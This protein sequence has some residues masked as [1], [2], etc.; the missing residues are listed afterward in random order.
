MNDC[1][2]ISSSAL[3][4]WSSVVCIAH[5]LA[6]LSPGPCAVPPPSWHPD[7]S[8]PLTTPA[9]SVSSPGSGRHVWLD[10]EHL[11]SAENT[12]MRRSIDVSMKIIQESLQCCQW[13]TG[14]YFQ[15]HVYTSV[16]NSCLLPGWAFWSHP[17]APSLRRWPAPPSA[18]HAPGTLAPTQSVAGSPYG[19]RLLHR[20][21]AFFPLQLSGCRVYQKKSDYCVI[22]KSTSS[23]TI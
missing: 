12:H 21:D 8:P 9:G 20:F 1:V 19:T 15:A 10:T 4:T 11:E 22:V 5:Q 7:A 17:L 2:S 6:P 14:V 16:L 13:L 18:A 23:R 3:F